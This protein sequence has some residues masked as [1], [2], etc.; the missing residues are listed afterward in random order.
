VKPVSPI[1][2]RCRK[3]ENDLKKRPRVFYGWVVLAVAFITI[4]LGYAI[5]NTFSVFYPAIVEEFGW[6]RGS[7]A[8]MFSISIVIYG[9]MAPV[10]GGIVDRFG[11]RLVFPIGACIMGVG[12]ALCSLATTQWQFYVLY[13]IIVAIGLSLAG[14]TP[15]IAIVS[16]W[17][18]KQR[19]L[20]FGILAAAFGLS[21][22]SA[23]IAQFLISSFNWQ[24]AYIIIGVFAIVVIVPLCTI[25]LRGNPRE[26]GLI[27]ETPPM[28]PELQALDE[29]EET[30]RPNTEWAGVN[31]TLAMAVKTYRFWLLFLIAFFAI[32]VAEQIAIAHQ[33]YFFR[34]L[35]YEPMVAATIYST[36]GIALVVGTLG[37]PISDRFGREKVFIPG[38]MLSAGAVCLLI[39]IRDISQPWVHFLSSV[40]FGLG[41]GIMVPVFYA[42]VADLFQGRYF[43][44]IQG[45]I[46]LGFSLGGAISPWLAGFIYDKTANYLLAL[47]IV[48]GSLVISAVLMWVIAPRKLMPV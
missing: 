14:W 12:L 41:F 23:P 15:L 21:L 45:V 42:T 16:N 1:N 7:T 6:G 18:V 30:T 38:C 31:W 8:L 19:G 25:F 27:Y 17:F 39:L 4:V 10:A 11:P 24:N 28:N 37:S 46:T 22:V 36:F 34:D 47:L 2:I 3:L 40:S 29:P 35:G 43:G 20:A 33:V 26:K 5:R 32:G 9:L 44:S 13:G 48:L